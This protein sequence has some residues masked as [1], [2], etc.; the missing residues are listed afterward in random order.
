[1]TANLDSRTVLCL[2]NE[3]AQCSPIWVSDSNGLHLAHF[4]I[5]QQEWERQERSSM[6][7]GFSG[8][9]RH[10]LPSSGNNR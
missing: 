7:A 9:P 6:D 10:C 4:P 5:F 8:C 1:M 3:S 2:F